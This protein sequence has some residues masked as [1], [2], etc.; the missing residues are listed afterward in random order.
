MVAQSRHKTCPYT[1]EITK[2]PEFVQDWRS[3]ISWTNHKPIIP[4]LAAFFNPVS[5][6]A[7]EELAEGERGVSGVEI[8][9][10]Q[11][12]RVREM[13]HINVDLLAQEETQTIQEWLCEELCGNVGQTVSLSRTS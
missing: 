4:L 11:L 13:A 9:L 2:E 7:I 1:T 10:P 3:L 12:N 5:E 8:A 6:L